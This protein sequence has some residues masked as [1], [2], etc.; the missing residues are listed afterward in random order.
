[1]S[2]APPPRWTQRRVAATAWYALIGA[3]IGLSLPPTCGMLVAVFTIEWPNRAATELLIVAAGLPIA[4]WLLQRGATGTFSKSPA[5]PRGAAIGAA[6]GG[7]VLMIL[8]ARTNA[9]MRL[10]G[11]AALSAAVLFHA[12]ERGGRRGLDRLGPIREGIGLMCAT[13]GYDLEATPDGAA[14]PECNGRTRYERKDPA[15]LSA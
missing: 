11:G 9:S 7:V 14:C 13:C 12:A 15:A 3:L 10:V 2:N 4:W 5:A 8:L 1:M 6:I